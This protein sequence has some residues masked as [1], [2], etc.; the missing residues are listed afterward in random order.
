MCVCMCV[1][2]YIFKATTQLTQ[3]PSRPSCLE[4]PSR[5]ITLKSPL[6]PLC[7]GN[8]LVPLKTPVLKITAE[9]TSHGLSTKGDP[10]VGRTH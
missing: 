4:I 6:D 3:V 1:Y 5:S 7:L 8:V 2:I 9:G 10:D